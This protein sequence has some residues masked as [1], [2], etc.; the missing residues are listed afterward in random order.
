MD[1][2]SLTKEVKPSSEKMTAFSTNGAGST[3]GYHVEEWELIHSYLLVLRSNLSGS[4]T[5]HKTR[6]SETYR[7]E[8]GRK[9]WKYGNRGK[10]L[11]RTAMECAVRSRID[12]SGLHKIAK[13]VQGKG[14]CQEDK[15]DHQ[16]IGKDLH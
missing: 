16:H 1:T 14:H 9:P 15:N 6:D 5:P 2:W 8:S 7:R 3:E 4:R 13:I 10:F 11:N 12:K